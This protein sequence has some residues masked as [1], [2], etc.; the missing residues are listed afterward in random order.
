MHFYRQIMAEISIGEE[1]KGRN[2]RAHNHVCMQKEKGRLKA[3]RKRLFL[4]LGGS[5]D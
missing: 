2:R 1:A 3:L 4:L 5:G